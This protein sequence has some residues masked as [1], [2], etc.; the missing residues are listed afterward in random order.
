[1]C[2]W[3]NVCRCS[4]I[5]L[6]KLK[7]LKRCLSVYISSHTH[8][9]KRKIDTEEDDYSTSFSTFQKQ[10]KKTKKERRRRRRRRRKKKKEQDTTIIYIG[11]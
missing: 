4:L 1:M 6:I 9:E 7:N 10:N 3:R 5:Q 8:I 2:V 11:K